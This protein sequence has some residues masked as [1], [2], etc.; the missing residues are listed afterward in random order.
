MIYKT[1]SVA[2]AVGG[3]HHGPTLKTMS[4]DKTDNE[5]G[6][7]NIWHILSLLLYL[8]SLATDFS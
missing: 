8:Q 4:L 5:V 1:A 6:L 7:W 2:T 3:S